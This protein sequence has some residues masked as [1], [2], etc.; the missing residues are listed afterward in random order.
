MCELVRFTRG[1]IMKSM[2]KKSIRGQQ[3]AALI[4]VLVVLL[5]GGLIA[6]GLLQHMGAG[7]LSGEVYARR[8][9]ELYGA[10]A[11]VED[12]VWGIQSN[13]LEFNEDDRADLG[14]LSVNDRTVDVVIYRE[15]I[16]GT[17]CWPVFM[18]QIL[19]TATSSDG[20]ST[21]V[22]SYVEIVTFDIFGGALASKG[23][24]TWIGHDSEVT[25]DIYFGGTL[26]LDFAHNDG[27]KIPVGPDA[28]PSQVQNEAFAQRYKEQALG[29]ETLPGLII[30][31]DT[32]CTLTRPTYI[33]GDIVMNQ[34]ATLNLAGIL[35][36]QGSILAEKDCTIGG[37]GSII[38]EE[39][40]ISIWKITNSST[41][42]DCII[43]SLK[44]D[45][46]FKK[47]GTIAALI[48]APDG[49]IYFNKDA[50][51]NGG[52]VG[53]SIVVKQDA[54]LT[55]VSKAS[56]LGLPSA[57]PDRMEIRTYSISQ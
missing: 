51:V 22:E 17:E 42:G 15:K 16:G 40:D 5:V 54:S 6:G 39:G 25:G 19:S 2:V 20:S 1:E 3:G 18:Y 27:E 57:F 30:A 28:F 35:Y 41:A 36:V 33:N 10:D 26:D 50:T 23:D 24:I 48:Y 11:G 47:E 45:I 34:G 49:E 31:K 8:T 56:S 32:T 21:T 4:L 53:G 37:S 55:Y 52:I 14:P 46:Y 9:A 12:A 44:G 43:M 13:N 29:G 38:A 7:L